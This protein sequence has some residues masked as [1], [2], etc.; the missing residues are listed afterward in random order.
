MDSISMSEKRITSQR[1]KFNLNRKH[2]Y[3]N[4]AYMAPL[5]K[6]VEN[7]GIEGLKK[8][9]QPH[10]IG[11]DEFFHDTET[12]KALFSELINNSEPHR[13]AI[14]PSASYG[15]N[16]AVQN[17]GIPKGSNVI[18]PAGQFPSNVYPWKNKCTR[19]AATLTII[20]APDSIINRG[21]KWNDA[22]LDAINPRTVAVSLGHVHWADGTLFQLKEIRQKC[23]DVGA[24]LIID[25][26]QSIGA[27][28]F[29]IQEIQPDALITAGYKWLMGPYSSGL[30]YYGK[31]FDEGQPIEHNWI[32][33]L[34]SNDFANLVNYQDQYQ[35]GAIRYD[36]G[37]KSNFINN[38]ML[39]AAIKQIR[40][41]DVKNIQSYCTDLIKKPIN[42]I[43]DMGLFV[44]NNNDRSDHLFGIQ[45]PLEKMERLAKALKS[46]HVSVSF[47]GEFIRVSPHVYND[48]RDMNRLIKALKASI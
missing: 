36:M 18:I 16:N 48:E 13:I 1:K 22:I 33:R 7:A 37:E 9:R 10:K 5:L 11:G 38:P 19:N 31:R 35:E 4:C 30:A 40:E 21:R 8:K 32:N 34:N 45:F 17:I 47:R 41:W 44:E 24:A 20:D 43:R 39:I 28:P 25:G 29:D 14:I 2:A 42:D 15:I 23:N 46:N 6:K 27:L 26:T 12:L 3:L